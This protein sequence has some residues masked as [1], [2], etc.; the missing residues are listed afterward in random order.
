M[1]KSDLFDMQVLLDSSYPLSSRPMVVVNPYDGATL[2]SVFRAM[3]GG[4]IDPILV[5]QRALKP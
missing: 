4:V 2:E 1:E 3:S 5:G